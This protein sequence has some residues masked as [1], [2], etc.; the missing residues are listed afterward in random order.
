MNVKEY[1]MGAADD[2]DIFRFLSFP[3]DSDWGSGF[4]SRAKILPEKFDSQRMLHPIVRDV[5]D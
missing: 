2:D 1:F 5:L 3:L 4:L